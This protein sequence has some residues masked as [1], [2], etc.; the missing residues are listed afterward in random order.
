MPWVRARVR[1]TSVFARVDEAGRLVAE[2]GRV[3]VRYQPRDGRLYRAVATN[4]EIVDATV[5]P[6]EVCGP[7]SEVSRDGGRSGA[8]ARA[9]S[10][11]SAPGAAPAGALP[12]PLPTEPPQGA[13]LAYSDGACSGN[14]GPAGLGVVVVTP[15]ERIEIAE[16]LGEGTNNIA[17]LTAVLRALEAIDPA[18]PARIYTDSRYAIGVIQQGWK[19][20]ANTQLVEALRR[21]IAGRRV[22]LRYVPGHAGVELNE[23]ADALARQAI[24][25]RANDRRVTTREKSAP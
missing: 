11:R 6:D 19:A 9:P 4:V 3:E 14:P 20:K 16:F 12:E 13:A 25:T 24:A 1:G 10:A 7:A 21:R 22:E 2:G 17:E 23:R 18:V 15:T 8:S 5:L